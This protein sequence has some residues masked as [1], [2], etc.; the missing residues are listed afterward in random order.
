MHL[1]T[2]DPTS[3]R[4]AISRSLIPNSRQR[5]RID[6]RSQIIDDRPVILP[7]PAIRVATLLLN[8]LTIMVVTYCLSNAMIVSFHC[9]LIV[10]SSPTVSNTQELEV[11]LL[12]H[13]Y[14]LL[15]LC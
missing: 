1:F 2:F 13:V 6:I 12:D 3:N 5:T 4:T 9:L 14:G 8:I 11:L 15:S 7:H 10:G